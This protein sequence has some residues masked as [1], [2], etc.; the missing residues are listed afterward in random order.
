MLSDPLFLTHFL[1]TW[2]MVGLIWIIQIVHYPLMAEVGRENF[3]RYSLLHNKKISWVVAPFMLL[4]GVTGGLLLME[5]LRS[6]AFVV[7]LLLLLCIWG[8][9][10]FIQV[11]LHTLLGKG[12]SLEV[13]RRLVRS[14]WIRTVAW[15]LRGVILAGVALLLW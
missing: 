14:N 3:P 10:A 2:F 7:S 13:H 15:T 12:L 4:E 11:P 8:S 5:G 6:P 9:T 1:L